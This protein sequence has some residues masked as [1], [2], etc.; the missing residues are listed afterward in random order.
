[1]KIVLHGQQ[2][3]GSAVLDRLISNRENVIAVCSAPNKDGKKID[4]LVENA[5]KNKIPVYQPESWK[6]DD[7]FDL[8]KSL[9]ADLCIMAY[10]LLIIP[11]QILNL[12]KFGSIQYHPS[13]LPMHRGPSSINWPISMGSDNTGITIFWPDDGLDTG[14][15][16]LQK[17]C[18]IEENETLGEL[19]FN[20]LFPMGVDAIEESIQ[21]IR[22]DKAPKIIQNISDGS[23]ESWFG[24]EQSKIEWSMDVKDI[25]ALIR[26]SDPQPG[27]W[28]TIKG[29]E[30]KLY[31]SRILSR[32]DTD[33]GRVYGLDDCLLIGTKN[34]ILSFNKIR[35][36]G[37][38]TKALDYCK[39]NNIHIG[40]Y[41]N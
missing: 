26:A 35:A 8:M 7:A 22:D 14:P 6:T 1:M 32:E 16:L 17:K 31:E 4:P 27:A 41:F 12:P 21:L 19:Y 34:G 25:H 24:K 3:F 33:P 40:D 10:V 39:D 38:K 11:S 20:K 9:E 37:S 5:I 18:R 15:I 13:L 23:Y 28:S 36:G 30:V 29:I 2:A